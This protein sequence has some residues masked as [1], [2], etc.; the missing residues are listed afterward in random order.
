[1]VEH[2]FN[3]SNLECTD[4]WT[5]EFKASLV[6][7]EK[8]RITRATQRNFV[9]RKII[10]SFVGV[11]VFHS[12]VCD[13]VSYGAQMTPSGTGP[14]PVSCSRQSLCCYHCVHQASWPVSSCKSS[15]LC[16]SSLSRNT[17]IRHVISC[18]AF[19]G[20]LGFKLRSSCSYGKSF[21][22]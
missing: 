19:C 13:M 8:S 17:E 12:Y 18:L 2:T 4:R 14:H 21:T 10:S 7:R 3:P 15:C 11:Y 1:M 16:F 20:F 22:H 5:S 6:Y 9:L